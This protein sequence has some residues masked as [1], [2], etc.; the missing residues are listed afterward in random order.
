MAV[1]IFIVDTTFFTDT[2][3]IVQIDTTDANMV[4]AQLVSNLQEI[5]WLFRNSEGR[6]DLEFAAAVESEHPTQTLT[7]DIDGEEYA[8]APA[9]DSEL[10]MEMDL[11]QNAIIRIYPTKPPSLGHSVHIC[12][13]VRDL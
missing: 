2:V 6:Y 8:W 1:S 7:V 13:T 10:L 12:L 9:K 5:V 4:C 11:K 3:I